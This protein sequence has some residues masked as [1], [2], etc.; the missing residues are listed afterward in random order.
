V[1][2]VYLN[3]CGKLGGAETSLWELLRSVRAAEPDWELWLVLGEDG[4]LAQIAR[5]LG[6]K[7]VLLPFPPLLGRL[8]DTGRWKAAWSLLKAAEATRRYARNLG[9][10]LREARPDLVHTNGFKMHI[11]AARVCPRATPLV[12][13]IHDYVSSRRLM[14]RL[15]RLFQGACTAAIVNSKSVAED[16]RGVLMHQRI[17]PIYNAIDLQ[18]FSPG[19]KQLDLDALAGLAPALPGTIRVG[20]VGTFARWKGHQVFLEAVGR[21]SP[22]VQV[23]GYIIGGP[24]YQTDGSQWSQAELA[25]LAD[26]LELVGR[27]GFTGFIQDVAPAMRSL[28]IVVHASTMPEPFGMVIIE[29]MA[30][31]KA[32][33]ASQAG[34]AAELFVDGEDALGHPPG[35]AEVLGQQIQRLAGD[36]GLRH[37]LGQAGRRKAERLYQGKR[38][39]N[40]V[41]SLY[42]ELTGAPVTGHG[43]TIQSPVAAISE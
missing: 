4:P 16:L 43:A 25:Q 41:T 29:A 36:P 38:L 40:E 33:I 11:L 23:R 6:V 18:R 35:D 10:L 20:L 32:V 39:A 7:V 1:R 3:P 13:H 27:L 30:C 37:R 42:R 28:D 14:N 31:G 21:L 5:D 8:G 22:E 34:G 19:G 2:I 15:L 9:R 17:V 12:W 24:I 26:R